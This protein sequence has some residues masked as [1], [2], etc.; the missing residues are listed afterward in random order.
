MNLD[1][2]KIIEPG[3][4]KIEKDLFEIQKMMLYIYKDLKK[5]IQI[6]KEKL[7]KINLEEKIIEKKKYNR[8]SML[9]L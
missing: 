2:Y 3:N 5:E 7:R 1:N 4:L 8:L 9:F 6:F